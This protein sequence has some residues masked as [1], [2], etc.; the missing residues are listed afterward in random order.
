MK[1][2]NYLCL[3]ILLIGCTESDLQLTP[4]D[5]SAIKIY[6]DTNEL[7][8]P[9]ELELNSDAY[10][11]IPVIAIKLFKS[12]I[13]SLQFSREKFNEAE[14]LDSM[15]VESSKIQYTAKNFKTYLWQGIDNYETSKYYQI[16]ELDGVYYFDYLHNCCYWATE[17]DNA[18]QLRD[19]SQGFIHG[20]Y[21]TTSIDYRWIKNQN[22]II[23]IYYDYGYYSWEGIRYTVTLDK[24]KLSGT[25]TQSHYDGWS[26]KVTWDSSGHGNWIHTYEDKIQTSGVF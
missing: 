18:W 12:R 19:Y 25:V 17:S 9:K 26:I 7:Q 23:F 15:I 14:E 13:E 5:L 8:Y 20:T 22:Q 16:S 24:K 11:Q 6:G 10:A 3:I 4:S 2:N 21:W 1:F